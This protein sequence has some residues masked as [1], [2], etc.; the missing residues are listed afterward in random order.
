[1]ASGLESFYCFLPSADID[2]CDELMKSH[3]SSCGG[4]FLVKRGR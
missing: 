4:E 1:L 2:P 3:L